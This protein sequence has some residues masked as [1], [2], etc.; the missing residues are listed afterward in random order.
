[1]VRF[2][3]GNKAVNMIGTISAIVGLAGT[4]GAGV[5]S[6]IQNAKRQKALEENKAKDAAVWSSLMAQDPTKRSD[7]AAMLA[8][9]DR[10]QKRAN[11]IADNKDAIMGTMGQ[12]G[13]AQ[14]KANAEAM[15]DAMTKAAAGESARR[16]SAVQAANE[17]R[18]VYEQQQEALDKEK[19]ASIEATAHNAANLVG[20]SIDSIGVG[21]APKQQTAAVQTAAA[22]KNPAEDPTPWLTPGGPTN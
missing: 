15:A 19:Y 2:A 20:S 8:Q 21:A 4:V 13:Y 16:D 11:E 3:L 17:S 14:R 7:V 12:G 9:L 18:K 1:M 6:I 22:S 5:S 10:N